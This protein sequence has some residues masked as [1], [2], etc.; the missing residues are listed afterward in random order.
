MPLSFHRKVS[1][2]KDNSSWQIKEFW[3]IVKMGKFLPMISSLIR[4]PL[5]LICLQSII[6]EEM[7]MMNK[8]YMTPYSSNMTSSH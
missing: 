6:S 2:K 7:I 1:K 5:E 3:S 8:S 4:N